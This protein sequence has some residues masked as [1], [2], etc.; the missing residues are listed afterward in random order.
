MTMNLRHFNLN[1]L[2]VFEA[3]MSERSA[4]K[5]GQILGLSQSAVSN[6]LTQLRHLFDDPLFVRHRNEMVPTARALELATPI[7]CALQEVR[8][9][10]K[11]PD[12]FEP[13]ASNRTFRIGMNDYSAFILLGDIANR[14][15]QQSSGIQISVRN[16]SQNDLHSAIDDDEVDLCI[17]FTEKVD[18]RHEALVL[19]EDEWVC[20]RRAIGRSTLTLDTYLAANHVV[21][22]NTMG[23]HVD[24]LLKGIGKSR[25]NRISI[26]FCL[27]AP[28]LVEKSDLLLT[29]P[30]RLAHEFSRG[31][32]I[33][34]LKLPFR[35]PSFPVSMVW[36]SRFAHDSGL[37]WM[38]DLIA[39]TTV[40]ES[41]LNV[42]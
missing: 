35:T 23:N 32:N 31:R 4:T 2:V 17:A 19:F 24:R 37:R 11:T 8:S 27:A 21:V 40:Q 28:V 39:S 13:A 6:S 41:A 10:A 38:R 29:L 14:V 25:T 30:S 16:I 9:I 22:G 20:A 15:R 18:P 12:T 42:A 36:H 34:I 3:M 1:L 5:T 33:E 26:P 7:S